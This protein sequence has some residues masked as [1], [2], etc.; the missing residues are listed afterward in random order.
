M[1]NNPKSPLARRD[2]EKTKIGTREEI[3]GSERKIIHLKKCVIEIYLGLLLIGFII[4]IQLRIHKK[5]EYIIL[6]YSKMT[7][8]IVGFY[9]VLNH[10]FCAVLRK[11]LLNLRRNIQ[12]LKIWQVG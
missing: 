2:R 10:L 5:S 12:K 7:K 8:Y 1:I 11:L 4:A 9:F 3:D 6:E